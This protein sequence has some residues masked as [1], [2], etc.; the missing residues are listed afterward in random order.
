MI[1]AAFAPGVATVRRSCK[2]TAQAARP[3]PDYGFDRSRRFMVAIV[4][5]LRVVLAMRC[6]HAALLSLG[7]DNWFWVRA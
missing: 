6:Q 3:G 5:G 7:E 4:L 2:I 1:S